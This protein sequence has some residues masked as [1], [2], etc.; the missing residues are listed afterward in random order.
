ML[1]NELMPLL[2]IALSYVISTHP[3]HPSTVFKLAYS[4]DI[5]KAPNEWSA[6]AG[7]PYQRPT[8]LAEKT[9]R[10]GSLENPKLSI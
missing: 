2:A 6:F 8:G 3:A 5:Q 9:P 4:K 10:D 7:P 1:H